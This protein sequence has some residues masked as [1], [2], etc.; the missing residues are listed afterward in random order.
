[1]YAFGIVTFFFSS[2]KGK[3]KVFPSSTGLILGLVQIALASLARPDLI[4]ASSSWS[5]ADKMSLHPRTLAHRTQ[6]AFASSR[7]LDGYR[8][9]TGPS[10]CCHDRSISTK[11]QDQW[12]QQPRT[13]STSFQHAIAAPTPIATAPTLA[14]KHTGPDGFANRSSVPSDILEWP[15]KALTEECRRLG[16]KVS[17]TK[18]ILT[19]RIVEFYETNAVKISE[20]SL[21]NGDGDNEEANEDTTTTQQDK[22]GDVTSMPSASLEDNLQNE[23]VKV[24]TVYDPEKTYIVRMKVVYRKGHGAAVGIVVVDN[25]LAEAH[26]AKF[27]L[28]QQL[29]LFEAEYSS[30]HVALQYAHNLGVRRVRLELDHRIVCKQLLG[31]LPVSAGHVEKS[32]WMVKS[33]LETQM[34]HCDIQWVP[35]S[36]NQRA[37]QLAYLA[38]A[39]GDPKIDDHYIDH[40][41]SV[42]DDEPS[43]LEEE[44]DYSEVEAHET[45]SA[46]IPPPSRPAQTHPSINPEHTFLLQFDGGA[47]G[48]PNGIGAAGMVIVDKTQ[49]KKEVWYGY[50]FLDTPF[51]DPNG[52]N[53]VSGVTNNQAEYTGF[54]LGMEKALEMGIR[55]LEVEGDSNLIVKQIK[56]EY[57]VRDATLKALFAEAN[58]LK[59]QFD[60]FKI[61]HIRREANYRADFLANH[62]MDHQ[63]SHSDYQEKG[64]WRAP[65]N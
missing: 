7:I 16:L 61:R 48:N 9:C 4:A 35:S 56:G 8:K 53:R 52:H 30:I 6:L 45:I 11:I 15:K 3:I 54:L 46:S 28:P 14:V 25:D 1:M 33:T 20:T 42:F 2:F 38:L 18:A 26:E 60:S 43:L 65:K 34:D 62:A 27:F 63:R 36:E 23:T 41:S 59:S 5:L 57:K 31:E 47:R 29:S 24:T 32:Y 10:N 51:L 12:R 13:Y 44:E 39:S 40:L 21:L 58:K 49:Q 50:K 17:G 19:G 37:K 55:R 64:I 22:E